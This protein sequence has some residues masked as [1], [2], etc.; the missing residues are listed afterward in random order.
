MAWD[1]DQAI[2]AGS[3]PGSIFGGFSSGLTG[4]IKAAQPQQQ[5]G[6]LPRDANGN[7]DWQKASA[8][9][10]QPYAVGGSAYGAVPTYVPGMGY[11]PMFR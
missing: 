1:P 5:P 7:V 11:R 4:G 8:M 2:A 10:L 9:L 3:D 6:G